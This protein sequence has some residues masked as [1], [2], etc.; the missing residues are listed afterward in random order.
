MIDPLKVHFG[1]EK[2]GPKREWNCFPKDFSKRGKPSVERASIQRGR[3][4]RQTF[5]LHQRF[6]SS[7]NGILIFFFVPMVII[8]I[9]E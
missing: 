6:F 7:S 9:E 4:E 8:K 2:K 3:L 5:C 1:G